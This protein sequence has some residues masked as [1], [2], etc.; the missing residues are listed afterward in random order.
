MNKLFHLFILFVL[1]S[2][3]QSF[4][5]TDGY[6]CTIK[7]IQ[8]LDSSG[9][10]IMTKGAWSRI[11]DQFS[12]NR[13]TGKIH[14]SAFS[15]KYFKETRV[16][17]RGSKENAYKEIIVSNPPNI[18]VKYIYVKEFESSPEKPFWGSEDG[19]MIFSGICK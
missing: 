12:I 4:A 13:D 6:I 14:G 8:T 16:L 11:G 5:G 1:T 19:Y 2:P 17:S 15:T 7:Q 18:W 10:F 9:K 3:A